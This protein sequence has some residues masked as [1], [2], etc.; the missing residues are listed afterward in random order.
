MRRVKKHGYFEITQLIGPHDC[1]YSRLN[2]DHSNLN[3]LFI[4]QFM[5][6]QIAVSI[7]YWNS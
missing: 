5:K 1:V 4:A 6:P 2:R 3:S 7:G